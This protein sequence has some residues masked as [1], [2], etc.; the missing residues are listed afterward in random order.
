MF[1]NKVEKLQEFHLSDEKLGEVL[2]TKKR[3]P[4]QKHNDVILHLT[5]SKCLPVLL[6][7]LEVCPLTKADMQSLNFCVN[8]ILMKLFVTNNIS[9]VDE[10]R[11]FFNFE[12]PSELLCK[13]TAKFLHKLHARCD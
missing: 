9:I 13:R 8:R 6:Y 7:G 11:H 1:K 10:C 3:T 5:N 2:R 12:L 4:A